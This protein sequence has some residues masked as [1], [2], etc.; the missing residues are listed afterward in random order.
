MHD[1]VQ[2]REELERLWKDPNYVNRWSRNRRKRSQTAIN[3]NRL[4][5]ASGA[6]NSQSDPREWAYD[7]TPSSPVFARATTDNLCETEKPRRRRRGDPEFVLP[8]PTTENGT[9]EFPLAKKTGASR[10]QLAQAAEL[11]SVGLTTKAQRKAHCSVLG[12]R[13]DCISNSDHRFYV[14]YCCGLRYCANCG[15]HIFA[16]LFAKYIPLQRVAH[17]LVPHWPVRNRK[18]THVI[19]KIDFTTRNTGEMPTPESVKKFNKNIRKFFRLVEKRFGISRKA[20]GVIWCDEFGGNNSNLHAHAVYAG[21]FLP[22]KKRELSALWSEVLGEPAMVSIKPAANFPAA[23]AHALKYPGKYVRSSS[24]SRLAELEK[25]FHRVR[26]V[27]ALA[28]FYNVK[29]DPD[30][31]KETGGA[32]NSCPV[33]GGLLE[34]IVG[35]HLR[36]ISELEKE[37]LRNIEKVRQETNRERAFG[38]RGSPESEGDARG[39]SIYQ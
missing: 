9:I 28:C 4:R 37:G 2:K 13:R 7:N 24:P 1:L 22:Q 29:P 35:W 36:P 16:A 15:P 33:C 20:Y 19:A 14:Q 5:D 39:A 32:S 18:L 26:R 25:A 21:P 34:T 8:D 6:W 11:Y 17:Q 30:Q 23:L 3:Q 10:E 38:A 12:G 31:A 27:H